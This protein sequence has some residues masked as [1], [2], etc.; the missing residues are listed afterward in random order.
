MAITV[1]H[2][3]MRAIL[4]TIPSESFDCI[5]T[6]PPYG[7]TSLEWDRWVQGWPSLVARVLK[8][9]G[10]MW[11]FGSFRMFADH[12]DEFDDFKF[13]HEVIWE[14]HNGSGLFNDRFRRV[15]EIAVHFYPKGTKWAD[16][17]KEP[18]FTNDA[19]AR[20]VRKKGRPAQWI[21]ATGETVYRSEDG[22]PRLMRSVQFVRSEHGRAIHPTQKPIGIIQPL[23][24]YACP[25]GGSV[26]DPFSGSGSVGIAA[27]DNGCNATL[28]ELNPEYADMARRRIEGDAP[29]FAE[30]AAQ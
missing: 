26:L 16:V 14:K 10:S 27:K 17:F 6:D 22:G 8:R 30:V 29:L 4:D 7:E 20:V 21:G 12:W 18:Q 15:H 5:V 13:S 3:D 24:A 1:L 19:R 2:G 11:V 28:I 9:T 23:L 25:R